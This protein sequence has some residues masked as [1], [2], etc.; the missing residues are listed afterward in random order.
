[1]VFLFNLLDGEI[2]ILVA[3]EGRKILFARTLY[4]FTLAGAL[5]ISQLQIEQK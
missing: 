1:M 5:K 3:R 2:E 4:L